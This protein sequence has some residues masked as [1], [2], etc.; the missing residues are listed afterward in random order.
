[1]TKPFV[2]LDSCVLI[3][4]LL[5]H[6]KNYEEAKHL[7]THLFTEPRSFTILLSPLVLYETGIVTTRSGESE[8]TI[9]D[10]LYKLLRYDEV[11]IVSLS[12]LAVFKHLRH[13]A[14]LTVREPQI[15]TQDMLILN[16]AMEFN[17]LLVSF[18]KPLLKICERLGFAACATQQALAAYT[19]SF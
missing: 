2:V 11:V 5:Q 10:R 13:T 7:I 12:D 3:S 19:L 6:D 9:A 14:R 17:A 18:D 8:N 15:K 1:V 16:T 4:F